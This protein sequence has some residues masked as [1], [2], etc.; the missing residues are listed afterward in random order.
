MPLTLQ[1]FAPETA[2]AQPGRPRQTKVCPTGR[3]IAPSD[4]AKVSGIGSETCATMIEPRLIH[5]RFH[6]IAM[7]DDAS[8]RIAHVAFSPELTHIVSDNFA[9]GTDITCQQLMRNRHHP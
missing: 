8:P 9:G 4:Q 7:D 1:P 6:N 2:A 5:R 3:G